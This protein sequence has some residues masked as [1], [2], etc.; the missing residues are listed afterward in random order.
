MNFEQAVVVQF[1]SVVDAQSLFDAVSGCG[2]SDR[3]YGVLEPGPKNLIVRRPNGSTR[4]IS[5]PSSDQH[6]PWTYERL[7]SE[8]DRL[9]AAFTRAPNG[10]VMPW[11]NA[12][13]GLTA[14]RLE[15]RISKALAY[16]LDVNFPRGS[17]LSEA[18]PVRAG[19][20]CSTPN[21]LTSGAAGVIEVKVL[22]GYKSSNGQKTKVSAKFNT[23]WAT[24]GVKQA[25]IY[26][27]DF[28]ASVAYLCCFDA[29]DV[30]ADQPE[31][32]TF[33]KSRNVRSK[34]Y[35]MYRSSDALQA[36]S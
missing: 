19:L 5:V 8:L 14:D 23:W 16:A 30:D 27:N 21:V 13:K 1:D 35:F 11:I 31:V 25:D 2:C 9:H 18:N 4:S 6:S 24:K 17:V 28:S 10:V 26:R 7:E 12:K 3:I 22:R 29:R 20:T 36:A 15:L 33:A 34:R 32:A